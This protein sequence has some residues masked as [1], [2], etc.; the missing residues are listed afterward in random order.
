MIIIPK[1][2]LPFL[3]IIF[4]V[5]FFDQ[6]SKYIISNYFYTL[7][8]KNYI[9]FTIDFIKNDGAAFNL[10]SENI[11][12]LQLISILS[13]ILI[14]ILLFFSKKL[15]TLESY[16]LSFILGGSLGNGIDRIINGFVID[17]INLNFIEFPIFNIADL[18]INIG[19]FIILYSLIKRGK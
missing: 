4:L 6:I 18:S 12:F 13:S 17:F 16:G 3:I 1:N 8:F 19:F 15:N 5:L 14:I 11:I 7:K 2:K 10:F 9:L